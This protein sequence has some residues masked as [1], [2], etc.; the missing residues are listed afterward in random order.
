MSPEKAIDAFDDD[1]VSAP[2]FSTPAKDFAVKRENEMPSLLPDP[3]KHPELFLKT[4]K[5]QTEVKRESLLYALT[6]GPRDSNTQKVTK[7]VET[8]PFTM[9][10]YAYTA[11]YFTMYVLTIGHLHLQAFRFCFAFHL[12]YGNACH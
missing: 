3:Y 1:S 11:Q 6:P 9:L 12:P 5:D 8:Y 7:H 4:R 10:F 2:K